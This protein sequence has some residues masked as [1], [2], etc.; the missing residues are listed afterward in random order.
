LIV[1]L[2]QI[3]NSISVPGYATTIIVIALG[4]SL[5]LLSLGI[6][7]GYVVRSFENSTGRPK[8]I[9]AKHSRPVS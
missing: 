2:G 1:L 9:V 5:L 3:S 8:Y 7:G 4:Q 6:I